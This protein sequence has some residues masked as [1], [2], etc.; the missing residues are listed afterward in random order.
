MTEHLHF[1][2]RLLIAIEKKNSPTCVGLDPVFEDL[3]EELKQ[4]F[5]DEPLM[6]IDSFCKTLLDLVWPYVPAVKPQSAYFERYGSAGVEI[7][8]ECVAVAHRRGLIVI[9]D[10]K[11]NDIGST[12]AAYAEGHLKRLYAKLN[13]VSKRAT[14]VKR[15]SDRAYNQWKSYLDVDE[16]NPDAVTVNGYLGSD[17]IKPFIE[18]ATPA[19]RG[20]FV[21]VR[22]SNKSA[23]ELQ[24]LEIK[25]GR[26][27]VYEHMADLVAQL[28]ETSEASV[29]ACGYSNV[30]AVVGATYPDD[31]RSL[32]KRMPRQIFLV[33]GYGAQGG[34]A[35]DAAA[36]FKP[37]G[38]GAIVNASRA[39]I[40]AYNAK[41]YA[42]MDWKKAIELAAKNFAADIAAA[43]RRNKD[44]W[45]P[46]D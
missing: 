37:D 40:F 12:A 5:A 28:G 33:P 25:D 7:F 30:G 36:S 3:P 21:L 27:K 10:V 15:V 41:P 1:A 42:G 39:V 14:R 31:A 2:D 17:G 22:T 18:K 44:N 29:G 6:A 11:R 9:S 20:L 26:I 16:A 34:T 46:N 45:L 8:E 19:G 43:V 23:R 4:K 13:R 24:D 32:R 35:N 38:T